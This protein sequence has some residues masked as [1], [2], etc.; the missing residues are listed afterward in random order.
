MTPVASRT[1]IK[2]TCA[3]MDRENSWFKSFRVCVKGEER[4]RPKRCANIQRHA[5]SPRKTE[6]AVRGEELTQQRSYE[7]EADVEVTH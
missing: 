2:E 5:K 7:V 3:D 4:W 6:L 1:S